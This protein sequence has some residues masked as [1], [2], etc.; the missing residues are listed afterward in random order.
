MKRKIN[1]GDIFYARLFGA[2]GSEQEGNR[3]VLIIQNDT[4][5]RFSRTVIVAPITKKIEIKQPTHVELKAFGDLKYDST[6]LAE[7]IRT[8]DKIRI[9]RK[10]GRVSGTLMLQVDKAISIATGVRNKY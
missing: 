6:I 1:R 4:G 5:N 8:I 3:P 9:G 7:Q 2:I 10:I